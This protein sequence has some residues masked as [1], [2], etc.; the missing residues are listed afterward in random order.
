MRVFLD[1]NV[2]LDVLLSRQPFV[3]DSE[4]VLSFADSGITVYTPTELLEKHV[5]T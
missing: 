3:N 1:A 2:L 5:A 4:R